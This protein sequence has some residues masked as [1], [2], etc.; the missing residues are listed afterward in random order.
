MGGIS[1]FL[2]TLALLGFLGFIAGVGLAV[3]S[4]SQGRPVRGGVLL[5]IFGL[6]AGAILSIVGQGILIVEPSERAVIFNTLS[7]KLE[8]PRSSGTHIII[9]IVQQATVYSIAQDE[10]TMSG[11]PGEGSI[12]GNDAVRARSS[13]GQEVLLEITILYRINPEGENVNRI[14]ENLQNRYEED[15]LRPVV[16]GIAREVVAGFTAQQIYSE[17]R[18]SLEQAM[19]DQISDSMDAQGL[20][21]IDLLV[22]DI[23][24]SDE[25][26]AS[27]EQA[28][29]A[30]QESERERELVNQQLARA[31]QAVVA[32]EG[33][34]DA[35]IARAQGDAQGIILRAQAEAEALRLVSEQIAA[36][37]LLI[38]YEYVVRL[39]DNIN[40]ALVPSDSPFLFDFQGLAG[41][42]A[43]DAPPIPD[44]VDIVPDA[45]ADDA[46]SEGS[47][48]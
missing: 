7:G 42:T 29:I 10:Y 23:T 47:D 21:M 25:F 46:D 22:R 26:A 31:E 6:V 41:E 5:A 28:Q 24:F 44:A 40:I 4:A 43:F 48:G 39:S 19:Q 12:Q 2:S 13:D 8:E 34:R 45:P 18:S 16:R 15:F 27:I 11:T 9:P 3:V 1:G 36:N 38:Q 37:P 32:A 30:F 33:A 20:E 35:E 14:H 17:A